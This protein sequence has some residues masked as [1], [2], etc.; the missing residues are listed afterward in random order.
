MYIHY[1][2]IIIWLYVVLY[3]DSLKKSI[4]DEISFISNKYLHF[5]KCSLIYLYNYLNIN[6]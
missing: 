2:Y 3:I 5:T 1:T 4:I 6:N